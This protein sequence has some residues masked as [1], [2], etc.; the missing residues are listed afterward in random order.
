MIEC[1][2]REKGDFDSEFL[3]LLINSIPGSNPPLARSNQHRQVSPRRPR[4]P[5]RPRSPPTTP[6]QISPF[7]LFPRLFFFSQP[8][9]PAMSV[10]HGSI[11][12]HAPQSLPSFA[13]AFSTSTLGSI[14]AGNNS[15][16]PIQPRLSSMDNRRVNSPSAQYSSRPSSAENSGSNLVGK[17]RPRADLTSRTRDDETSDSEY[18]PLG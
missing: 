2:L 10:N 18:V 8:C 7:P 13:Q 14:S 12:T 4:R 5:P 17:K 11:A 1:R 6:T 16:P 9:P 15:L 3:G